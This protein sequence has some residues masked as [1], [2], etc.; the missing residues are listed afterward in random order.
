[1]TEHS[2]ANSTGAHAVNSGSP[3]A[4][5]FIE[6]IKDS[7]DAGVPGTVRSQA[8][9]LLRDT[10]AVGIAGASTA[11]SQR[12][13]ELLTHWGGPSEA[14]IWGGGPLLGVGGAAFV[15]A[16]QVHTLEWDPI[17]EPGVVHAMSLVTPCV[18][19]WAQS[20]TRRGEVVSGQHIVNGILA[21]VDM[22]AGLGVVTNSPLRFFR[23]ATNGGMGAV[24]GVGVAAGWSSE[25]ILAALGIVYG[26]ISGTMQ[27]HTEG[28]QVLA[29]QVGFNARAAMNAIDLADAGFQGPRFILEGTYGYYNLIETDGDPGQL[30][31]NKAAH[32]EITRV[33]IKPFPSGRATHGALGGILD[34][35][36]THGFTR[37]DISRVDIAVPSMV[38]GLVGRRPTADMPVGAAR[39]CLAYLV[40]CLLDDG[41][42]NMDTYQPERITNPDILAWSERV[43][44]VA[45]DN[46]DPN[47]FNPQRIVITLN[48][49]DTITADIPGSLGSPE[50]PLSPE[51]SRKKFDDAMAIG[52]RADYA[53]A[54][55][56]IISDIDNLADVADLWDVL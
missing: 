19:A 23:P 30:A 32:W 8:V 42:I 1:M 33:G 36:H 3:I 54:L 46:P 47:A 35:Q 7:I 39:L 41:T 4:Y 26:G 49:G 9:A 13:R 44:V 25:K 50:S 16:H 15:N 40:P 29:L 56:A 45:D 31:A 12:V 28:A 5:D 17:H 2:A 21:G 53:E 6:Q 24:V 48:S 43:S 14:A 37:S 52:G 38:R 10:V 27:P 51:Q 55:H 22:A 20:M 11:E 18:M 34:L